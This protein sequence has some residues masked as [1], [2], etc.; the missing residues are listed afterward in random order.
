[1]AT[2]ITA[3]QMATSKPSNSLNQARREGRQT[4]HPPNQ[5]L[6]LR[7]PAHIWNSVSP[8]FQFQLLPRSPLSGTAPRMELQRKSS[9]APTTGD[10]LPPSQSPQGNVPLR[11]Q[12]APPRC[13]TRICRFHPGGPKRALKGK[14]KNEITLTQPCGLPT[15][16]DCVVFNKHLLRFGP[17]NSSATAQETTAQETSVSTE[18]GPNV[19]KKS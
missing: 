13:E 6:Y 5:K 7:F 11:Y 4:P 2:I 8:S 19:T 18:T 14:F 15:C 9:K 16:A 10:P 1:M 17:F 3:V 12:R